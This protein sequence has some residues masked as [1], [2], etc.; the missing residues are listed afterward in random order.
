[1]TETVRQRVRWWSPFRP[2]PMNSARPP[3]L[4]WSLAIVLSS[5]ALLIGVG[6]Y[7]LPLQ[8]DGGW[9]SY[10][11][12]AYSLGRDPFSN[13]ASL[14][15]AKELPGLKA[16]F[17]FETTSS[18]RLFYV[19]AWFRVVGSSF[20][21][22][23]FLSLLE[24][25]LVCTL[26][27]RLYRQ[28]FES[29]QFA[30]LGIGFLLADKCLIL[31]GVSDFRPDLALTAASVAL[32]LV[33]SR[34]P[35]TPWG[36]V[37]ACVLASVT[38]LIAVTSAVPLAFVLVAGF[39]SVLFGDASER[40]RGFSLVLL[41]AVVAL[42][43]FVGRSALFH[44]LLRT[45]IEVREP[46]D[47][48]Q[49]MLAAL[50]MG[51]MAVLG[52]EVLRWRAYFLVSNAFQLLLLLAAVAALVMKGADGRRIPPKMLGPL[53][54]LGAG[55]M[56][57]ALLDPHYTGAHLMPLT[58]FMLLLLG[59]FECFRRPPVRMLS[60]I[61][62]ASAL[63]GLALG[64]RLSRS[65]DIRGTDNWRLQ[66][67]LTGLTSPRRPIVVLGPTELWPYFPK[68]RDVL[69]VDVTRNPKNLT[70]ANSLLYQADYVIVNAD[71]DE[72]TW[73]STLRR[74]RP[75]LATVLDKPGYLTVWRAPELSP[76]NSTIDS[77]LPTSPRKGLDASG[78]GAVVSAAIVA[79]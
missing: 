58:P 43:A 31:A 29:S 75:G 33:V 50:Q 9:Y 78:H 35:V 15:A 38:A 44:Q 7:Y 77:D 19:S 24:L 28:S 41:V 66:A 69:L 27:Y 25:A 79:R 74:L 62:G 51:P 53:L 55:V 18:V 64:V 48:V 45:S 54:G 12:F 2:E 4:Y 11:A 37:L 21:S 57:L 40:K 32:Y 17:D 20:L 46:V 68:D 1:M 67:T 47:P 8:V 34:R 60:V 30:V 26:A 72:E 76:G 71:Y 16:L 63:L 5:V 13:Q 52:K 10:P 61:L 65:N 73:R 42:V 56:A 49:R 23:K 70:R 36:V 6:I 59:K 39:V 14:S 3:L 22:L